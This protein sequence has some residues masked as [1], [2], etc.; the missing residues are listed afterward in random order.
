[1]LVSGILSMSYKEQP[2]GLRMLSLDSLELDMIWSLQ[3]RNRIQ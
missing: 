1:M 3:G 2:K